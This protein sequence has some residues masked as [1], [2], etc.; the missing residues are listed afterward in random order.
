MPREQPQHPHP[1]KLDAV[2]RTDVIHLLQNHSGES[3]CMTNRTER[4]LPPRAGLVGPW[5]QFRSSVENS[6]FPLANIFLR[7]RLSE[8]PAQ[9]HHLLED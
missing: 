9:G 2:K 3:G 7:V 1:G 6:G 8:K 5:K 4:R